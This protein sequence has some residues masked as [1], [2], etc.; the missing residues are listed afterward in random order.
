MWYVGLVILF[1][2]VIVLLFLFLLGSKLPVKENVKQILKEQ[3]EILRKKS[4]EELCQFLHAPRIFDVKGP[5][6]ES[7]QLEVTAFWDNG[8]PGNLR[9]FITVSSTSERSFTF[10]PNESFIIS[11]NGKFIGE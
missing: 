1:I 2:T 7:Y 8:K 9:V 4:Y 3:A 5:N 11:P 6:N 10:L